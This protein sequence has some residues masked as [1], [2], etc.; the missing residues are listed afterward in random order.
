MHSPNPLERQPKEMK[1]ICTFFSIFVFQ[2][3]DQGFPEIKSGDAI[4]AVLDLLRS[5]QAHVKEI[6]RLFRAICARNKDHPD[7]D[8]L[9]RSLDTMIE[10]CDEHI[11]NSIRIIEESVKNGS[12][13]DC[14]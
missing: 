13:T 3:D 2:A 12:L 4:E 14:K 1:L 9:Y 11:Q 7:K 8:L 6:D 5:Q 10:L